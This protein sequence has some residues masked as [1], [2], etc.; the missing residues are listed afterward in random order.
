MHQPCATEHMN[1]CKRGLHVRPNISVRTAC[2]ITG[3]CQHGC[4]RCPDKPACITGRR[5]HSLPHDRTANLS[6][7]LTS[8]EVLG[9]AVFCMH[10]LNLRALWVG[11][12]SR[13]VESHRSTSTSGLHLLSEPLRCFHSSV[14]PHPSIPAGQ[15]LGGF[16]L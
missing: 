11:W 10:A 12:K 16:M 7:I 5:S 15:R 13:I 9:L 14:H 2:H 6:T 3:L 8:T 1:K 4:T